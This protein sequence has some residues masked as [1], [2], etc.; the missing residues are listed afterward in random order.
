MEESGPGGCSEQVEDPALRPSPVHVL[1]SGG[2][3]G[4]GCPGAPSAVLWGGLR[5]AEHQ[6]QQRAG[7][8]PEPQETWQQLTPMC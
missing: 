8:T 3:E 7:P 2:A 4:C 5:V 1:L 6:G